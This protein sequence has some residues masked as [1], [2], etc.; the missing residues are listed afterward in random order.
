MKSNIKVIGILDGE[1]RE[2]WAESLNKEKI[3]ENFQNLEEE[4]GIQL[5]EANSTPN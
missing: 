2:E 3:A 4:L 1:K 5:H